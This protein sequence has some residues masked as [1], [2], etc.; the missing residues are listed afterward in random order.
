MSVKYTE[1]GKN[2]RAQKMW[3][4]CTRAS[5]KVSFE[6]NNPNNILHT[7]N[8]LNKT[9]QKYIYSYASIVHNSCLFTTNIFNESVCVNIF[10][11][12]CPHQNQ[13]RN[14]ILYVVYQ[15]LHEP[16][17]NHCLQYS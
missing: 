1:L 15:S 11:D 10:I 9:K 8:V 16:L 2:V 4:T 17:K 14:L 12:V 3:L 13:Q 7:K 6:K 5:I